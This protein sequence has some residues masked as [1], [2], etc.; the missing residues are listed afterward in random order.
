[1][2]PSCHTAAAPTTT[3]TTTS[4]KFRETLSSGAR[5]SPELHGRRCRP[6]SPISTDGIW[7]WCEGPAGPACHLAPSYGVLPL[8]RAPSDRIK[9]TEATEAGGQLPTRPSAEITDLSAGSKEQ[10]AG[11]NRR[12]ADMAIYHLV[13]RG[14]LDATLVETNQ[15]SVRHCLDN[16]G[17]G[18]AATPVVWHSGCRP[19]HAVTCFV[20]C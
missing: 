11:G 4:A 17:L 8:A 20:A 5:S 19:Q 9:A 13:E 3:T 2:Q 10:G 15:A 14:R 7:P 18:L 12:A 1:M 16:L 6:R